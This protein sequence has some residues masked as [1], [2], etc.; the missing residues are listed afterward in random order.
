MRSG[1]TRAKIKNA[2]VQ[3]K[4]IPIYKLVVNRYDVSEYKESYWLGKDIYVSRYWFTVYDTREDY[5]IA[6]R[7]KIVR[8]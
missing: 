3:G 6:S 5:I 7:K 4:E 1:M 2:M 8:K